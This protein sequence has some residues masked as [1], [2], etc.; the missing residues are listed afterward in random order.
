[1]KNVILSLAAMFAFGTASSQDT[2]KKLTAT[3]T[4]TDTV[5]HKESTKGFKGA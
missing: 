3:K 2:P 1:M 4:Q 5:V